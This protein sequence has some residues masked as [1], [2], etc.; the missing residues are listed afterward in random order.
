MSNETK[1]SQWQ[2]Y[3]DDALLKTEQV[4]MAAIHGLDGTEWASSRDFQV[5]KRMFIGFHGNLPGDAY[6]TI[7]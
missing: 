4:S 2:R 3:I 6:L 7:I 5:H 1:K